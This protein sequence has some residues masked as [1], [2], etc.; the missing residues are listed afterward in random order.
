[1]QKP[2]H[3]NRNDDLGD[4][5]ANHGGGSLDIAQLVSA[6][7]DFV[8]RNMGMPSPPHGAH[9]EDAFAPAM[10]GVLLCVAGANWRRVL[11][12]RGDPGR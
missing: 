8:Y 7:F 12:L 5:R 11:H 10:C 6:I 4:L 3:R 2:I 1:M 9:G